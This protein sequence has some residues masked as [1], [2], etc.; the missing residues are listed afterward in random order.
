MGVHGED[1]AELV[2]L[3]LEMADLPGAAEAMLLADDLSLPAVEE[4]ALLVPGRSPFDPVFH[5]GVVQRLL[6]VGRML[7]K[8]LVL[9]SVD[10]HAIL[11]TCHFD[12]LL[13]I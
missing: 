6:A 7:G 8:E 10:R 12:K 3:A 5:N 2:G 9:G 1:E 11:G 13:F 4:V